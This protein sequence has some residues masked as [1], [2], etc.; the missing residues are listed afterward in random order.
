LVENDWSGRGQHVEFQRYEKKIIDRILDVHD[1]LGSTSTAIVESVRCKRILL[2]RKTIRCGRLFTWEKAIEEVAQLNRL[3]HSHVVQ[4]IGTYTIGN[5]FSILMYPVAE[6][7]LESFIHDLDPR[8]HSADNWIKRIF[9]LLSFYGCLAHAVEHIHSK[10]TK[11][12]DI[13]PQN[14]LV[15]DMR[16]STQYI[17]NAFK[18]YIADFGISR[19]YET[20]DACETEGPTMFTRKYAA[21]EVVDRDKR[22]LSAD[23]FSLGCVFVEIGAAYDHFVTFDRANG[24]ARPVHTISKAATSGE[25]N[26]LQIVHDALASNENGDT[27]YQANIDA[28]CEVLRSNKHQCHFKNSIAPLLAKIP[29]ML[30]SDPLRRPLAS[31]LVSTF[32]NC[33]G[34]VKSSCCVCT[35][36]SLEGAPLE[37]TLDEESEPDT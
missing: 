9:S 32:V 23:I 28:V 3:D 36:D 4:V 19:S 17:G 26:P 5:H 21:P 20:L 30:S 27:S 1:V 2:A 10:M 33:I 8:T 14:I 31:C 13:K 37:P 24:S 11:H 6:Y 29:Q 18:I 34:T 15:R 25:C 35:A 16:S 12:M 7:N 22:G